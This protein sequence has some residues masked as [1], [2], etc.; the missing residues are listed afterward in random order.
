ME[1]KCYFK[2]IRGKQFMLRTNT[3]DE[4]VAKEACYNHID[5]SPDDVW[6][7]IGGNI[8]TFPVHHSTQVKAIHT[9]EPDTDNLDMLY[10]N[11]ELNNIKNCFVHAK[12]VVWDD[13]ATTDFYLNTKK[14][15]GAHSMLVYRG[16]TKVSVSCI[17]INK[18][19]ERIKPTKIKIDIEGGEY[20]LIKAITNWGGIKALIFEY[21][22]AVLRD[23]QGV[24]LKELYNILT[25]YFNVAGKLPDALT[26]NWYTIIY[27]KQK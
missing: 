9:Y 21:H 7:D 2:E 27:C 8:G 23:A 13:R 1:E 19:I 4:Y 26:G 16:R 22:T 5:F 15:K 24:R 6:L 25:P 10:R 11:L 14:N 12:A 17:N 18:I 3:L 20:E